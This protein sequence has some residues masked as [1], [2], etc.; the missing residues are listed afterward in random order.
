[1]RFESDEFGL[2]FAEKRVALH[3]QIA[4]LNAGGV[5]DRIDQRRGRTD[6]ADL[7]GAT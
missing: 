5:V 4:Y 3:G 6:G 2:E 7:P 1:M